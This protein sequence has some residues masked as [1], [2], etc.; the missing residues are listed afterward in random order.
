M[1]RTKFVLAAA[2]GM[3]AGVLAWAAGSAPAQDSY[4]KVEAASLVSSPQNSWARAILFTDVLEQAPSGRVQRLDRKNY[5]QMKLKT[6]GA[7]WVPEDLAPKFQKLAVGN[8]YS[9]AGTVDQI[10]RRYYVIVDA[11]YTIQ[12]AENLSE[13]WTD[14][15][16]PPADAPVAGEMGLSDT[17]MQTLLREAQNSLIQLAK[18]S[19]TTV[20][21]LIE[22]Q[23]DGGQR[24]AQHIVADA[25]QGELKTQ[26]K[27]AEELMI[28]AV[29]A[30]LQKQSVLEESAKI[31]EENAALPP[32]IPAPLPGAADLPS[33]ETAAV[34]EKVEIAPV[35]APAET[36]A[37]APSEA[38]AETPVAKE[39]VPA[40]ATPVPEPPAAE[41]AAP[42]SAV[43]EV[44]P[45]VAEEAASAETALVPEL[46]APETVA[47]EAMPAE[48]TP[49]AE[50][51]AAEVAAT[52]PES[53]TVAPEVA[54]GS[55][56]PIPPA[57][58]AVA[59][60]EEAPAA[61]ATP[62]IAALPPTG[63][64]GPSVAAKPD[65]EKTKK[66]SKKKKKSYNKR[67]NSKNKK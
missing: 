46:P 50:A 14:M 32:A 20:A 43:A 36:P 25:L 17:A 62:E 28:D 64:E 63:T 57:P 10:S 53:T 8:T 22:G 30:L 15:L 37:P 24:I 55:A 34:V 4:A 19:N 61:P 44:V 3:M 41:A 54:M 26:N 52:E 40:E 47:E 11:C 7:A 42:E 27:T 51:P 35:E 49:V 66:K 65:G 6:A 56:E 39:M 48:A 31:G 59:I 38:V 5:L 2:S 21:Q 60:P 1:K 13:L 58:E 33:A 16:N 12:T 67:R 29:L 23:T 9:F 45:P 18:D